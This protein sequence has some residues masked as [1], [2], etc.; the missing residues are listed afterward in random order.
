[1][2]NQPPFLIDIMQNFMNFIFHI[3]G[4]S[5]KNRL[6]QDDLLRN[7]YFEHVLWFLSI[8]QLYVPFQ[9]I[10]LYDVSSGSESMNWEDR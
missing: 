10:L 5:I 9:S 4:V 3:L 6:E 7:F 2:Q 1:M 8:M